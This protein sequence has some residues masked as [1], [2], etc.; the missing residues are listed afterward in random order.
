MLIS[1]QLDLALYILLRA[2]RLY[3]IILGS[4]PLVKPCLWVFLFITLVSI[5]SKTNHYLGRCKDDKQ[6]PHCFNQTLTGMKLPGVVGVSESHV[7]ITGTEVCLLNGDKCVVG[8]HVTVQSHG[9]NMSTLIACLCEIIQQVGSQNHNNSKPDGLL[10]ETIDSLSISQK[11]DFTLPHRF[12]V[13]SMWS[14]G[15]SPESMWTLGIF[16]WW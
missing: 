6:Q 9:P 2:T 11:E 13:E 14:P 7:Y 15:Q 8:Q 10:L 16:F 4:Q 12:H 1:G 3:R 5:G